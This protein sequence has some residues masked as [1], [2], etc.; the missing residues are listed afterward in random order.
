MSRTQRSRF[1]FFPILILSL[2]GC[3]DPP[4]PRPHYSLETLQAAPD[5]LAVNSSI[6]VLSAYLVRDFMP[7][8]TPNGEPLYAV[9]ELVDIDSA[10]ITGKFELN[11]LWVINNTEVWDTW[12]TD[13]KP[14]DFPP[15]IVERI[16]RNGPR[17]DPGTTVDVVVEI[18][19]P[20][21]GT[22]LIQA[23]DQVILSTY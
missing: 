23:R 10:D 1:F 11:Y 15:Y 19:G 12:F 21:G 14:P 5:T 17:W 18:S 4:D 6:L 9:I 22:D 20:G 13:E 8:T 2:F 3:E 7:I 16:A